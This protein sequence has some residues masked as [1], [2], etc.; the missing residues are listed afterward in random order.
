MGT[1]A[2]NIAF[3]VLGFV[4]LLISVPALL[5]HHD[6]YYDYSEGG[7]VSYLFFLLPGVLF[8]LFGLIGLAR[9]KR[10][11]PVD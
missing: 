1:R 6:E 5:H 8:F 9:F 10:G 3:M 11:K 7:W 4:C 2:S